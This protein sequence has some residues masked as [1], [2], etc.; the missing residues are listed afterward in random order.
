MS[1]YSK[2][3]EIFANYL[4]R[5]FGIDDHEFI[6]KFLHFYSIAY[7]Q[8]VQYASGT[9]FNTS[10]SISQLVLEKNIRD[11]RQEIKLKQ[12][13]KAYINATDIANYTFC[14]AS[15][16]V[17]SSF[18]IEHPTGEKQRLIGEK[19][20]KKLNLL[21]KFEEYH[22]NQIEKLDV[23][24]DS[25]ILQIL[26]A[27]IIYTGHNEKFGKKIFYNNESRI[28]CEPDY[29]FLDDEKQYFL[30]EEK[31][32]YHKDPR[33]ASYSEKWM[34][35]NGY[36]NDGS[37]YE[38][39]VNNLETKSNIF[40]KNHTIQVITYLK[41]IKEY[42]LKYAY[43]IYWYYD[44]ND[45]EPYIHKASVKR[46]ILNNYN[47]D[48]YLKTIN[49]FHDLLKNK[50]QEFDTEKINPNKCAGCVVNKYCGHK[51]KKYKTLTLPYKLDY[52]T[53]F[54]AEYPNN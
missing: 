20:H 26:N 6:S 32:H 17:N 28:A 8:Y 13:E 53:L 7:G 23:F 52:L 41:N 4:L 9:F 34:E 27:Q 14:P 39:R 15:Y 22:G 37:E 47:D 30:V 33:K 11:R 5:K 44:F 42:D 18:V 45:D 16:S 43:L 36:G 1:N 12:S 35:W 3:Q 46:I 54:R 2:K 31:Y 24:D 49:E 51:N 21:K 19:L 50:T 40:F 38:E 29:I 10:E 25:E 48:F